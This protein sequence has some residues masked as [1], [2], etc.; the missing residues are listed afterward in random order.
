MCIFHSKYINHGRSY[1]DDSM[2]RSPLFRGKIYIRLEV[3]AF[4]AYSYPDLF[5][6]LNVI[7]SYVEYETRFLS[8]EIC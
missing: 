6:V 8:R 1:F 4:K 3:L 7:W 5:E 2:N